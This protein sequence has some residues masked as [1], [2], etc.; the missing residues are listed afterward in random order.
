MGLLTVTAGG[1][2]PP[3]GNYVATFSGVDEVPANKEKGFGPGLRWK[4]KIAGGPQEGVSASRVTSCDVRSTTV[5][6]RL[7]SGLLGRGLQIGE[8]ID[9]DVFIGRKYMVVVAAG[10]SG[11]N[12]V[13]A[14]M[15]MPTT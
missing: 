12:R 6:G 4:F 15:P 5:G 1:G 11:S 9:P 13:E 8:Q 2:G 3:A 14:V 7:L 10:P